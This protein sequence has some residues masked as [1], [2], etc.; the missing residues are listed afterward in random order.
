MARIK[1]ENA[2]VVFPVFN[3]KGQSITSRLLGALSYG[4]LDH[5]PSGKVLVSA[6]SN[7]T[8]ELN[9]GDRVGIVGDNGAGK[10]T[11]LRTI[12][13]VYAPSSGSVLLDGQVASLI[14]ISLG[15]NPEASGRENIYYR[16]A[17]LG[18]SK[19]ETEKRFEAIVDFSELSEY[20]DLPIR[21]YSSG[22]QMRLG[23]AVSTVL[24]SEIL[25]MDEWLSVGDESFRDK[26]QEK[27]LDL[28]KANKILVVASHT[29][30][31]LENVTDRILW[32]DRGKI[33]MDGP[34][35]DVLTK[36]FKR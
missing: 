19:K 4:R 33:V 17:L 25:I 15:M 7:L 9:D 3:S 16:A 24:E 18:L 36:Y 20:I 31:L 5:D 30:S 21:T 13:G 1:F 32:L 2:S 11:L 27:L 14:D 35:A 34:T 29:R 10:S 28:V 23:F 22:M 8:F 26:A 12:S 6:L